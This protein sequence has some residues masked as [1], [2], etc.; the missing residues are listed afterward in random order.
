MDVSHKFWWT[1]LDD[2]CTAAQDVLTR[3]LTRVSSKLRQLEL[4]AFWL[5]AGRT[6]QGHSVSI[7]RIAPSENLFYRRDG[8]RWLSNS[9]PNWLLI[10]SLNEASSGPKLK[11]IRTVKGWKG[12]TLWLRAVKLWGRFAAQW[13]PRVRCTLCFS[14]VCPRWQY[15]QR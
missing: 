3:L 15:G 2:L 5:I 14:A 12:W 10:S 7:A 6:I 9:A 8:S 13:W 1:R 11:L 4:L